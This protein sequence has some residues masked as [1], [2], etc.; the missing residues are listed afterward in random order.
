MNFLPLPEA[1]K[2]IIDILRGLEYLHEFNLYHSDIKPQNILI[3]NNNEGIL[4]DY[5][6]S[7]HSPQ[8]C[9]TP[10]RGFYK[11][12]AAPEVISS[13]EMSVQTDIYQVGL[14]AFRLMNGLGTIR[15]KFSKVGED[16]FNTL[17]NQG[18]I[19]LPHD[20]NLSIPKNLKTIINK[21]IN[22]NP[23]KRY[24]SAL[25]FRRALEHLTYPGYW[26]CDP[27]GNWVGNNSTYE[28]TF[29]IT[30]KN[31]N[32]F[33]LIAYKNN[34]TSGRKTRIS[35]FSQNSITKPKLDEILRTFFQWVTTGA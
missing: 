33:D 5:G 8:G 22:T 21:S 35:M 15:D 26:T 29:H 11:L 28:F 1:I 20:Y 3:G 4:T 17:I 18:K 9:S 13:G 6:I 25:Q 7:C 34:K 14:T 30:P 16:G 32:L 31:S 19:V 27:S 10:H 12:H 2:F 23:S 24:Q